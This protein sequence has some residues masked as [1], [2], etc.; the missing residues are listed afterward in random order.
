M[1]VEDTPQPTLT[2]MTQTPPSLEEAQRIV[3]GYVEI[4]NLHKGDEDAQLL[5]NEEGRIKN[6]DPNINVS[7]ICQGVI[8]FGNAVMLKGKAMWT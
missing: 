8:V 5:V 4:I 1:I 2:T 6:F 7:R 3:G